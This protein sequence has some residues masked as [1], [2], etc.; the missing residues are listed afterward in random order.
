MP[1]AKAKS[2][3]A[4]APDLLVLAFEIIAA[5]GWCGFTFTELAERSNLSM[6]DVR[7]SFSGRAA[8]LD[9]LNQ[10]LDQAML[11]VDSDDM[12]GLPPKDRVFELMMSRLEAM[13]PMRAGLCRLIEDVRFDPGLIAM[14][15]CRLDRSLAWLQ[16]AAGLS[17]GH[18][19][20][21]LKDFRRRLQRRLLGAVYLQALNV[22]SSDE[23]PDL[24]KTMASLDK[25]LRR[26]ESLAGLAPRGKTGGAAD[27]AA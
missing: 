19:P 12:E 5:T 8:L 16:D 23:S 10:R 22:W 24:A 14:T 1:A 13:A 6:T 17:H 25:Q 11:A 18:G 20:S 27:A 26:I 4:K 9:A 7:K 3:Q 2:G 21:P 15:A